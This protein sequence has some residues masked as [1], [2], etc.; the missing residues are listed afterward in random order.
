MGTRRWKRK[1]E[2]TKIK[3]KLAARVSIYDY[4]GYKT[5][6]YEKMEIR[7]TTSTKTESRR[8]ALPEDAWQVEKRNRGETIS[9]RSDGLRER[10]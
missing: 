7:G 1:T 9:A 2:K 8:G 10:I 5:R 3:H 4:D 6:V